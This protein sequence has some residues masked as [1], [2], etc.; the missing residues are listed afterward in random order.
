[1]LSAVARALRDYTV[2]LPDVNDE[3]GFDVDQASTGEE[4]LEKIEAGQP[5][6]LLLDYKLPGISGLDVLDHV[7]KHARPDMLAIMM[8]AYASLETAVTATKR[9]AYDFLAKPFTPAEL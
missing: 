3:V 7:A 9:G 6:I 8:T 4:A 5:H 2:H 1:M